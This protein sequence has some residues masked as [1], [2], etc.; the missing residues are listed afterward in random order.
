[1]LKICEWL[2]KDK[3]CLWFHWDI[4]VALAILWTL[5]LFS[6]FLGEN[7][8]LSLLSLVVNIYHCGSCCWTLLEGP[9]SCLF[10]I[11]YV[12]ARCLF[13]IFICTV[14]WLR[15]TALS[16]C[17]AYLFIFLAPTLG[18]IAFR[19]S[20]FP[21]EFSSVWMWNFGSDRPVKNLNVQILK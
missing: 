9:T 5:F 20:F 7:L 16:R 4:T 8:W 11:R 10:R 3:L 17:S 6:L 21:H 18:L 14:T 12:S 2:L 19:L 15:F 1:M 13:L